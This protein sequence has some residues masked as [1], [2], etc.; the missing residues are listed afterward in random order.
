VIFQG[1]IE[2]KIM[3]SNNI[4]ETTHDF[5][6]PTPAGNTLGGRLSIQEFLLATRDLLEQDQLIPINRGAPDC[7][8]MDLINNLPQVELNQIINMLSNGNNDII[9]SSV[10]IDSSLVSTDA[11][12]FILSALYLANDDNLINIITGIANRTFLRTEDV[13]A[14][15]NIY[16][17]EL[18]RLVVGAT[19]PVA[20]LNINL[21]LD[22]LRATLSSYTFIINSNS[23]N[24]INIGSPLTH[25]TI[26]NAF[27]FFA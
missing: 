16:T 5:V 8:V 23:I 12:V 19:N 13:T 27:I 6:N 21:F 1:V 3:I 14:L 7:T 4:A 26:Q 15:N 9:I 22:S 24:L 17:Y 2:D 20:P 18:Y 10:N 25:L 11:S